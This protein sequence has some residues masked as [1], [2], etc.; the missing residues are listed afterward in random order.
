MEQKATELGF[1]K[2]FVYMFPTNNGPNSTDAARAQVRCGPT[3]GRGTGWDVQ[4]CA[5]AV[6]G[7]GDCRPVCLF[8]FVV[9]PAGGVGSEF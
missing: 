5:W 2:N 4:G 6:M 3:E 8:V 1:P 9:Q 7:W